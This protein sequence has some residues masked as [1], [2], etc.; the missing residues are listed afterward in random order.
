MKVFY[1]SKIAKALRVKAIMLF[2]AVFTAKSESEFTERNYRHEYIHTLQWR[3]VLG[4]GFMASVILTDILYLFTSSGYSFFGFLLFPGFYYVWYVM[5]FL[6][7]FLLIYIKERKG[8]HASR[9][10]AYR[11]IVFEQEARYAETSTCS[12]DFEV[13]DI[14]FMKYYKRPFEG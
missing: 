3:S 9:I 4:V 2:G 14:N 8:F 12:C 6:I 5:E 11:Y 10:K 1:E 7:R 13:M